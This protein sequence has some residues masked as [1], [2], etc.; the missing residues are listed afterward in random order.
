MRSGPIVVIVFLLDLVSVFKEMCL[1]VPGRWLRQMSAGMT[2]VIARKKKLLAT[3][4]T[5]HGCPDSSIS[6]SL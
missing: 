2:P 6:T 3:Q 1:D 4:Q 5:S